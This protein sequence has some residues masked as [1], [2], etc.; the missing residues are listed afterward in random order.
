MSGIALGILSAAGVSEGGW[1]PAELTNLAAW[2]DA[3]DAATI[4]SMS[5]LVSQWNDKSANGKNLV[6]ASSGSQPSTGLSTQNGRNLIQFADS[7]FIQGSAPADYWA[8]FSSQKTLIGLACI[9]ETNNGNLMSTNNKGTDISGFQIALLDTNVNR[10]LVASSSA[11][12][13][14]N[15]G[16]NRITNRTNFAVFTYVT[17]PANGTAA[18]RSEV[19]ENNSTAYKNNTFTASPDSTVDRPLLIGMTDSNGVS[20]KIG[21]IVMITGADATEENRLLLNS[22]LQAK[23]G[24]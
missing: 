18:N 13:V 11:Y 8:P 5:N 4:T 6:Q 16:N 14:I 20:T 12:V 3:S 22:Y 15:A 23:W 1:T 24:V 19:Y 17:D 9:P 7:K 2:Y 10:M 21:E